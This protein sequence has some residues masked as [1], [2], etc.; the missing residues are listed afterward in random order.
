MR[1]EEVTSGP[2]KC[3]GCGCDTPISRS[4]FVPIACKCGVSHTVVGCIVASGSDIVP[5]PPQVVTPAASLAAAGEASVGMGLTIT[6]G[7][8]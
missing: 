3:H 8:S 1:T 7:T 5:A 6:K 2:I 4:F